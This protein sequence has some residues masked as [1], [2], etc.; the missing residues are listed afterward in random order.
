MIFEKLQRLDRGD[1]SVQEYYQELQ[2]GMLRCEDIIDYKEYHSMQRLFHLSMLVEKEFQG[3]QQRR[4][5]TFVPRPPSALA[6]VSSSWAYGRPHLP[7]PAARATPHIQHHRDTTTSPWCLW[8]LQQ[9]L[10]R[11]R[12]PQVAPPTSSDTLPG[13]WPY[14]TRLPQQTSIH[15]YW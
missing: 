4:S 12:L 11:P 7:P 1:M 2:K 6:K 9:N 13:T 8:V 3:R 15:C 5:K 14:A 10:L